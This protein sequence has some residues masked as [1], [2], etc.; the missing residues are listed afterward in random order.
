MA[1]HGHV[2]LGNGSVRFEADYLGNNYN[3]TPGSG[4]ITLRR[5]PATISSALTVGNY[6]I[7]PTNPCVAK[8]ETPPPVFPNINSGDT[9]PSGSV[10]FPGGCGSNGAITFPT[11]D[12]LSISTGITS[13]TVRDVIVQST[14][15][16]VQGGN[17]SMGLYFAGDAQGYSSLFQR[18]NIEGVEYGF[19][20]GPAA[21]NNWNIASVGPTS[22]GMSL[23]DCQIHAAFPIIL[24]NFQDG[25]ISR[26]DTYTA[27]INPYDGTN[28]G[29]ATALAMSFTTNEQTGGQVT[30]VRNV[31]VDTWYS[32]PHSG[33]VAEFPAYAD[34]R[35]NELTFL[36]NTFEGNFLIFNGYDITVE[37]S[38]YGLPVINYGYSLNF[39]NTTSTTGSY[40]MT[41]AWADNS[42]QFFNWGQ[43]STCQT[44]HSD[45]GP[46]M[47]CGVGFYQGYTGHS[48]DS[49]MSGND[50][51]PFENALGGQILMSER[52]NVGPVFFDPTEPYWGAYNTCPGIT[53]CV[54]DNLEGPFG[55]MYVGPHNRLAAIPYVL[56]IRVKTPAGANTFDIQFSSTDDG[57]GHC[58]ST[59]NF[60]YVANNPTTTAWTMVDVPVDLTGKQGCALAWQVQQYQTTGVPFDFGEMNFVP[61][62]KSTVYSVPSDSIYN[63]ACSIPGKEFGT[64]ATGYKYVCVAGTIK[65]FGPAS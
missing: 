56:K 2:I 32:E 55:K 45:G 47:N 44:R 64:S 29:P 58:G 43:N 52:G 48:L 13:A 31:V 26:C 23:E 35:G 65:R 16:S 6:F 49:S 46:S 18:L 9:T 59:G 40:Y 30:I 19:A 20:Q 50:A 7:I 10:D 60:G 33:N 63:T 8:F 57:H 36:N 22:S 54:W 3:A 27:Y 14:P 21:K 51:S 53:F 12:G 37:H 28:I 5:G 25:K 1:G 39:V 38:S 41:N 42:S 62:T 11:P 15:N 17:D 24:V 61:D 34:I 4:T